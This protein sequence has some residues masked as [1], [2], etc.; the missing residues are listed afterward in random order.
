MEIS[1]GSL[2][3]EPLHPGA[4]PGQLF[5]ISPSTPRSRGPAQGAETAIALPAK[6]IA[7]SGTHP[8]ESPRK[9]SLS[10]S[11]Y[12]V[13]GLCSCNKRALRVAGVTGIIIVGVDAIGGSDHA[14]K[15]GN[16]RN[17]ANGVCW[18]EDGINR[19]VIAPTAEK[20]CFVLYIDACV[21]EFLDLTCVIPHMSL[22]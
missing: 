11:L 17:G 6:A 3:L 12:S 22:W 9:Y 21:G 19:G 13:R 5:Y 15:L 4:D 20:S 10:G 16:V 7:R 14:I 2:L 18:G 8:M 1:L